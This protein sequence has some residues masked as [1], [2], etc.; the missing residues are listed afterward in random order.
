MIA[1]GI[2]TWLSGAA[3]VG[4]TGAGLRAALLW[5]DASAV[6]PDPGWTFESPEPVIPELSQMAWTAAILRA[7][8][9]SGALNA[10]AA[11]WTAAAVVF[12]AIQSVAGF[13]SS[14]MA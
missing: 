4:A 13:L 9:D 6:Q 7:A 8:Q 3:A 12:A 5:W 10:R 14:A 11:R 2:F 1:A